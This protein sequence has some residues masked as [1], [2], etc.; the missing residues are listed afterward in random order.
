MNGI[1]T[2]SYGLT[3]CWD[4]HRTPL[5]EAPKWAK[6][7]TDRKRRP[8][9]AAHFWIFA[10]HM[11]RTGRDSHAAGSKRNTIK[12]G[13]MNIPWRRSTETSPCSSAS[14]CFADFTTD[15]IWRQISWTGRFFHFKRKWVRNLSDL[16]LCNSPSEWK[17]PVPA[18]TMDEWQGARLKRN[19]GK[20][21]EF[22]RIYK[23]TTASSHKFAVTCITTPIQSLRRSW[24]ISCNFNALSLG[25]SR[26]ATWPAVQFLQDTCGHSWG[27]RPSILWNVHR[28]LRRKDHKKQRNITHVL[29][30]VKLVPCGSEWSANLWHEWRAISCSMGD[31]L[32]CTTN[33]RF[34]GGTASLPSLASENCLRYLL[35]FSKQ[36]WSSCY[37]YISCNL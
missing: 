17:I 23:G 20:V 15:Q 22:W 6:L 9:P 27:Y 4:A 32:R 21:L 7:T 33:W 14:L 18:S 12:H 3:N 8:L 31:T 35:F 11:G 19:P 37:E 28:K 2:P 24:D 1:I 26:V 30:L 10:I 29:K 25:R 36:T 13:S 5:A 16:V 34:P